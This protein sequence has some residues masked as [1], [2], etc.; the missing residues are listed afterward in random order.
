MQ[1]K[2]ANE[3]RRAL[4][5]ANQKLSPEQRLEAYLVHCRLV[6]QLREASR[7]LP[8]QTLPQP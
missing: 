1:S 4:V 5:A 6:A 3:A 8:P 2:L 7:N